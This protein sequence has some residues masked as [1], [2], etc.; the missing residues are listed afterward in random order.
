M[1]YESMPVRTAYCRWPTCRMPEDTINNTLPNQCPHCH[2]VGRWT[3][4][5]PVTDRY[6]DGVLSHNDRRFLHQRGIATWDGA[7]E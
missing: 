5:V 7:I 2:R 3:F 4:E 1:A 6:E